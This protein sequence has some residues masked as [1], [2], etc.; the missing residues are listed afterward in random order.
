MHLVAI[1]YYV[2]T[3]T[4]FVHLIIIICLIVHLT[5]LLESSLLLVIDI[6]YIL[7]RLVVLIIDPS[8]HADLML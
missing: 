5:Y 2:T 3:E 6:G 4:A 8:L 7:N 1:I